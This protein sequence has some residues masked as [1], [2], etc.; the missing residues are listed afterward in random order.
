MDNATIVNNQS[1]TNMMLAM[2]SRV[3]EA[4]RAGITPLL[5]KDWTQ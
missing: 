2:P 5:N 3:K 4:V 1:R